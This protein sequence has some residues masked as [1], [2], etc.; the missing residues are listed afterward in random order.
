MSER[1]FLHDIST[2]LTSLQM[3]LENAISILE[4]G[5]EPEGM[6]IS[7]G[8]LRKCMTQVK[9]SVLLVQQRREE[10]QKAETK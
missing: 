3:D 4:E 5:K 1:K 10:V 8:L 6:A 9:K 7:M 2:P